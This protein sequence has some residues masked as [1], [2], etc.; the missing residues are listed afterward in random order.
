MYRGGGGVTA[1]MGFGSTG[2][3]ATF[4]PHGGGRS[5]SWMSSSSSS[6]RAYQWQHERDESYSLLL[7]L[8]SQEPTLQAC[9][10]VIESTCLARGIML[11]I[12]G[13]EPSEEFRRFVNR[14]YL[15]FAESA[16]RYFFALGFVPWRLRKL[17]TGDVV[18]EAIP[19]GIFTWSI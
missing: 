1:T 4:R 6:G 11:R 8:C 9:F 14:H 2:G 18:P 19:L 13:R 10:K 3:G 12:G 17:S 7:E 15:P 5:A 16:I